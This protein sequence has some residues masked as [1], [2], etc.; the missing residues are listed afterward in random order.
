MTGE[1][2][3][4]VDLTGKTIV[5]T[6]ANS[7]IGFEIASYLASKNANVN[8]FCRNE[9]RAS[10]A[11]DKIKMATNNENVQFTVCDVSSKTSVEKCANTIDELDVLVCNAGVL[12]NE[13]EVTADGFEVTVASHLIFGSYYLTKLLMPALRNNKGRVIYVS[14]GGM[15]NTKFPVWTKALSLPPEGFSGNMAYAYAKRGQV[16]LAERF[17]AEELSVNFVSC[18]P[19]WVDT[20]AV[21]EAYGSSKR[22]LEPM[23][24]PWQGAEGI[25]WL[26]SCK[27]SCLER[28]GFYLD[29]SPQKKHLGSRTENTEKEVGE[30]VSKLEECCQF[31]DA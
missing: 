20:P 2:S 1:G 24:T 25:C 15:Y 3:D 7:G 8:L 28:G 30:L 6:G 29:R 12:K 9:A 4:G 31:K 23:R 11:V 26:A 5:V 17:S 10:A 22:Y 18:H 19:G 21:E 14:S 13:R 16:L 27:D